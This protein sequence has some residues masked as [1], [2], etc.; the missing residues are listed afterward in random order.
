[1]RTPDPSKPHPTIVASADLHIVH[2]G[3]GWL[4][5]ACRLIRP[6]ADVYLPDDKAARPHLAKHVRT[7][8]DT[9]GVTP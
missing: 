5:I 2:H 8:H 3:D 6:P 4:C 1:M 7:G 9:Q